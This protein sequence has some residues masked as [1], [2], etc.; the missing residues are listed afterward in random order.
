MKQGSEPAKTSPFVADIQLIRTRARE[1]IEQ[2]AV[3]GGY[4]ADRATQKSFGDILLANTI[5]GET[6]GPLGL[7]A[8]VDSV[9]TDTTP[10]PARTY[11]T[12]SF[13]MAE[14]ITIAESSSPLPVR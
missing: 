11:A 3:T 12:P 5:T 2:G 13:T 9:V 8:R 14:R 4:K 1:H 7:G 6:V 10:A